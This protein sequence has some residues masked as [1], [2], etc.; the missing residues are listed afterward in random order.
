MKAHIA[1]TPRV[2][3]AWAVL[4]GSPEHTALADAASALN[5]QLRLAEPQDL[6]RTIAQLCGLPQGRAAAAPAGP[7]CKETAAVFCG[8]TDAQ[9]DQALAAL[10]GV[11]IPLKAVVTGHNRDWTLGALLVELGRERDAIAAG[12]A[13]HQG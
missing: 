8:L 11:N 7:G 3:L 4:P 5:A 12:Q 13:A 9:L 6:G 1:R 10:R 2:I